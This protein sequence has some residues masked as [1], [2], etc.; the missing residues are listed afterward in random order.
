MTAPTITHHPDCDGWR[1]AHRTRPH[2]A[3]KIP[4]TRRRCIYWTCDECDHRWPTVG[5]IE[6]DGPVEL[7]RR[8][9]DH[10]HETRC[11]GRCL[12]RTP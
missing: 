3:A 2:V 7:A 11:D 10:A 5:S 6:I 9:P 1:T 12:D 8:A 4:N